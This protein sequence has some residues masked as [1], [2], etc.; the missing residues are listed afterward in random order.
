M[1]ADEITLP[2]VALMVGLLLVFINFR[3]VRKGNFEDWFCPLIVAILCFIGII[4]QQ[5]GIDINMLLR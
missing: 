3:F 4:M 5:C 2:L 1:A